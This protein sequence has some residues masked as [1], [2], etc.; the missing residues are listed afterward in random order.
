MKNIFLLALALVLSYFLSPYIGRMYDSIFPSTPG[1]YIDFSSLIGLPLAYIF[2][3]TLLF[4]AFGGTKKYWW[5]GIGLIPA[6]LF[7]VY[8]DL[9]H[10]Y[11]PIVIG[12][13]SWL[14]GRGLN[15]LLAKR[16]TIKTTPST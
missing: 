1:G 2:F 10:L 16:K 5:I 8:F 15:L 3:L 6:V 14:L 9:Q 11:F 12:L 13:A 4:T 7:E